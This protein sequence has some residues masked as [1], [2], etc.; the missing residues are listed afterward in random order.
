MLNAV[1][2]LVQSYQLPAAG[3]ASTKPEAKPAKEESKSPLGEDRF[4]EYGRLAGLAAGGGFASYKLGSQV[5][6][7]FK[8]LAN[9]LK[10]GQGNLQSAMPSIQKIAGTSMKGAGL[11][12][13]V[14]AGVSAVSNGISVARGQT[15][16]QTALSNVV[17]DG[18]SGAIG[19]FGAVS[20]AGMGTLLLR[21]FGMAGLPLTIG[22]VALGAV[23]GIFTGRLGQKLQN[24]S[25]S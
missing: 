20:A 16:G 18:V 9:A 12:A 13:L 15:D 2:N 8:E 24:N 4:L 19:G 6:E 7:Q 1:S 22:T 14:A 10:P 5:A 21:S 11:S 23:G 17:S 25:Q 3:A